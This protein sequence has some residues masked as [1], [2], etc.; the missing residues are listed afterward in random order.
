MKVLAV[1]GSPRKGGNSTLLLEQFLAGAQAEGATVQVVRPLTMCMAPCIACDG[2][3]Q[4]G[5]C[6]VKDDYQLVYD[7]ILDSDALVLATPIY[8]GAVSAILKVFI[9]RCQCF[10]AST[11]LLRQKLPPGPAGQ[12]RKGMLIAVGHIDQAVMFQS[13]RLT[14]GYLIKSLQGETWG[15]L[16]CA[17]YNERGA[18]LRSPELLEQAHAMGRR[19]ALGRPSSE[20]T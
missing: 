1:V 14:F 17:G 11:Y 15:E 16:C 13:A 4:D 3:N 19:L 2:C 7:M 6:V 5:H 20:M 10:W 18:I 8:F 12:P 9:D